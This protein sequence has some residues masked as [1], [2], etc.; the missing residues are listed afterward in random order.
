[1]EKDQLIYF[2]GLFYSFRILK[3]NIFTLFILFLIAL[4][5][6]Y[7]IQIYF[8]KEN[9]YRANYSANFSDYRLL[10]YFDSDQTSKNDHINF[11]LQNYVVQN[12]NEIQNFK[13]I[14]LNQ[15]ESIIPDLNNLED[16]ENQI[17]NFLLGFEIYLLK[18]EVA[19]NNKNLLMYNEVFK[20]QKEDQ[21]DY[22]FSQ[23]QNNKKNI[24]KLIAQTL[25][26]EKNF[27]IMSNNIETIL[28]N[29][30]ANLFQLLLKNS[31]D[32]MSNSNLK[33]KILQLEMQNSI[34]REEF[35]LIKKSTNNNNNIIELEFANIE[36]L[37]KIENLENTKITSFNLFQ[38]S[39][40]VLSRND[41]Y[42]WLKLFV[43]KIFLISLLI[44]LSSSIF[45]SLK[46]YRSNIK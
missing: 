42:L 31:I 3:N 33:D 21:T 29:E 30:D 20:K 46:K 15:I 1:M 32:A 26:S 14:N 6:S 5:T 25:E 45:D 4:L 8:N 36:Y 35:D 37:K 19:K 13:I 40:K 11:E 24:E 2:E 39:T 18:L 12:F 34:L 44:I 38:E 41:S 10:N 27:I 23:I 16:I 43:F 28:K 7:L 9:L 17:K 22:L